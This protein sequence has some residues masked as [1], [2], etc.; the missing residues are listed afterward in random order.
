MRNF[1]WHSIYRVAC[2]MYLWNIHFSIVSEAR[3]AQVNF[4]EKPQI[5][6]M[7]KTSRDQNAG[8]GDRM[9]GALGHH[10]GWEPSFEGPG[11][12]SA[13]PEARWVHCNAM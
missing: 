13:N 1:K 8:R 7:L 11:G 2:P 9:A 6:K 10:G 12:N 3:N 4:V 5:K